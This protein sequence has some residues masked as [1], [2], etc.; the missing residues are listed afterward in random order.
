MCLLTPPSKDKESITDADRWRAVDAAPMHGKY[1]THTHTHTYKNKK[2]CCFTANQILNTEA[3]FFTVH[4]TVSVWLDSNVFTVYFARYIPFFQIHITH[5][6][7]ASML[8]AP[9]AKSTGF[10]NY[11]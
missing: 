4:N 8:M 6:N 7:Q 3:I 5:K 2:W 9:Q 11:K 1:H 10:F